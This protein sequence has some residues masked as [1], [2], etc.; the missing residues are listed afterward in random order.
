M[1]QQT[2]VQSFDAAARRVRKFGRILDKGFPA[3][4][5]TIGE[6]VMTDVKD[7]RR[8]KGVPRDMGDLASTGRVTGKGKVARTGIIGDASLTL[9]FGGQA[10]LYA[11]IQHERLDFMHRLGEPRY[12]VRG[13]ERWSPARSPAWASYVRSVRK[14]VGQA[15][16]GGEV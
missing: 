5:R 2:T 9:S 16:A 8:G 1:A 6:E 3:G 11:L 7:S 13:L 4:M 15:A 10:S 14:A 12:L